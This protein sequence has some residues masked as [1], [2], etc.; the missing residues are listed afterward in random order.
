MPADGVGKEGMVGKNIDGHTRQS[1]SVSDHQDFLF[2][3]WTP[4]HGHCN[5]QKKCYT[6]FTI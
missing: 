5:R 6:D 2:H 1:I 4:H 3:R